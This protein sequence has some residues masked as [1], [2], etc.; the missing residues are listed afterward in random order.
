MIQIKGHHYQ[1]PQLVNFLNQQFR[2]NEGKEISVNLSKHKLSNDTLSAISVA[3]KD[4]MVGELDLSFAGIDDQGAKILSEALKMH[5]FINKVD[6]S[7]NRIANSGAEQIAIAMESNPQF[8][9]DLRF[10]K[11]G[12]MGGD[13]IVRAS[14]KNPKIREID[15]SNND[16]GDNG[17]ARIAYALKQDS[18]NV[19]KLVLQNNHIGFEGDKALAENV[20]EKIRIFHR[21]KQ[22]SFKQYLDKN[23]ALILLALLFLP[24]LFLFSC[25]KYHVELEGCENRRGN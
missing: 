17:A 10:N 18:G 20:P 14:V 23:P 22:L 15:L 12:P 8:Q 13:A 19:S 2:A 5:R 1:G 6:L 11:I 16:L 9:I 7:H 3:L 24:L 4:R 21:I 25:R